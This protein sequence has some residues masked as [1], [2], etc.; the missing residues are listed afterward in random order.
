G[1]QTRYCARGARHLC[2]A[3]ARR[4]LRPES[5]AAV[6]GLSAA[7]DRDARGAA[8]SIAITEN[9]ARTERAAHAQLAP[10]MHL[11]DDVLPRAAAESGLG[12]ISARDFTTGQVVE[13][14]T[15]VVHDPLTAVTSGRVARGAHHRHAEPH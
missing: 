11:A 15:P 13:T 12:G 6:A 10:P 9:V 7:L 4:Q 1:A 3:A 5:V 14:G 8:A 2:A